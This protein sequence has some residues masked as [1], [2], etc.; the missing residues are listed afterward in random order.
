M[1]WSKEGFSEWAQDRMKLLGNIYYWHASGSRIGKEFLRGL[2][3]DVKSVCKEQKVTLPPT[4]WLHPEIIPQLY[5]LLVK[6]FQ[7][8]YVCLKKMNQKNFIVESY[9]LKRK[10][11]SILER[12]P[13]WEA[14]KCILKYYICYF[15]ASQTWNLGD[16]SKPQ[17]LSGKIDWLLLIT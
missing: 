9:F 16:F 14:I 6:L 4:R 12:T 15:K 17:V 3:I 11:C 8:V 7:L 13:N 5:L 10:Q 2:C 1:S